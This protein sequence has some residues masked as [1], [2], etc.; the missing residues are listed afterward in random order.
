[1]KF[2]ILAQ[3]L[4][5]MLSYVYPS[6][7]KIS[8][9]KF[10]SFNFSIKSNFCNVF[11]TN[12][13][14]SSIVNFEVDS[15][16][17]SSFAVDSSVLFNILSQFEKDE[18]ISLSILV[19]E[20]SKLLL[21]ESSNSSFEVALEIDFSDYKEYIQNI[22]DVSL[23]INSKK[24][25]NLLK[26]VYFCAGSNDRPIMNSVFLHN[27]KEDKLSVVSTD[28]KKLGVFVD[29]KS[30]IALFQSGYILPKKFVDHLI[31]L[32]QNFDCNV[33]I[34]G[35]INYML[36]KVSSITLTSRLVS[37]NFPNYQAIIPKNIS[38]FIDIKKTDILQGLKKILSIDKI[39]DVPV[40]LN[41][42]NDKIILEAKSY[43]NKVS[44]NIPCSFSGS[45]LMK[46]SFNSRAFFDILSRIETDI[47]R[48]NFSKD[49][50]SPALI[51]S[52]DS[53]ESAFYVLAPMIL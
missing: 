16:Q 5:K 30:N 14:F 32:L 51:N 50:S 37:G 4:V 34:F 28:G 39:S 21:I 45:E 38:S 29:E 15:N 10:S 2:F 53:T 11:T 19:N 35:S 1:M 23:S 43:L 22:N 46:I 52:V 12:G 42:Y 26:S 48:I 3:D 31:S 8:N 47:L 9:S 44:I 17:D 7:S 18:K 20:N 13:D 6:A 36:I 27:N 49:S 41:I 24:L 33:D 40:I 25:L